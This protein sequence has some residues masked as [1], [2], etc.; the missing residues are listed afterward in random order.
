MIK[1]TVSKIFYT[2]M[3]AVLALALC[4]P[5][6]ALA[7][8][9]TDIA[10]WTKSGTCEWKIDAAGNLIV[11][12]ASD[13]ASGELDYPNPW[14]S[15]TSQIK[16]ATFKQ[17]VRV[18]STSMMFYDCPK[19]TSVDLSGLDTS[20]ATDMRMMFY[21]CSSLRSLDLSSFDTSNATDMSYMFQGCSKLSSLDLSSFNTSNATNMNSMFE[22]CYS[23]ESLDLSSFDTTYVTNMSS[24]FYGCKSLVALNLE[25]LDTS[26]A[27]S[28][29]G[30]FYGCMS[31]ASLD[32]SSFDTSYVQN[33]GSM[34]G[35]CNSLIKVKLGDKFSF[36]GSGWYRSCS[37][38]TPSG[39]GY[40]GKWL[41]NK[42]CK[43][44]G[45]DEA[46]SNVAA[47]YIAQKSTYALVS[48]AGKKLAVGVKDGSKKSNA[49]VQLAKK[50]S[51]KAQKWTLSYDAT[52]GTYVVK[53]AKSGKVLSVKGKVKKGA[54]VVQQ[55]DSGKK[56]QRWTLEKTSGGYVLRNA[57]NKKLVLAVSGDATVGSNMQLAKFAGG[58]KAQVF[59]LG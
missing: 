18:K 35:Q 44:Y 11:R 34:F 55:K 9:G 58:S 6:Q 33:M 5:T 14:S 37:L 49:N 21:N 4:V 12:P 1:G 51:A 38:P 31:L 53:N 30:M 2:G 48:A 7:K 29:Y 50:S 19:L 20:R 45:G 25:G 15:Y 39:E 10:S 56:K 46:P 59:K 40:T 32:L 22:N 26:N 3:A 23:L 47:T 57:A 36:E 27:S 41:S 13:A 28:M 54:N 42:D 8:T 24:M 17:G 52:T 43:T 16:T